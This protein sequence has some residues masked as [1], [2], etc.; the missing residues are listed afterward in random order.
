M[1][2]R[3]PGPSPNSGS[4][5]VAMYTR[6]SWIIGVATSVAAVALAAVFPQRGLGVAVELPEQLG[7][8]A[9]RLRREA[10]DPAVAAGED[11]LRH[12]ADHRKAGEDHCPCRMFSP[13]EWSAQ[14][15]L[16]VFLSRAMKLGASGAGTFWC[17][18]S[19]PL[20]RVHQQQIA[21]GRHRATAHVV[22]H[23]AQCGGSCRSDQTI[24]DASPARPDSAV[25][26]AGRRPRS[27][28]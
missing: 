5:P 8:A 12:A 21:G 22:R 11:G 18:S 20:R 19:T 24:R 7:L 28:W 27:G 13:G 4:S 1:H 26:L 16:P 25:G 23:D 2:Q 9:A 14:T 17:D 10:V 3:W 6:P 15:S